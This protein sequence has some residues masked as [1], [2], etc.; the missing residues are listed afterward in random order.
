MR[1]LSIYLA[2]ALFACGLAAPT[3]MARAPETCLAPAERERLLALDKN[4]FDLRGGWRMLADT[5]G[6]EAGR[7]PD[8]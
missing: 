6:C 7:R 3:A 5:P 4:A 2:I 1:I 8:P